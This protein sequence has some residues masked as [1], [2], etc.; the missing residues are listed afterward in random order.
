MFIAGDDDRAKQMVTALLEDFGWPVIDMGGIE[1][2]LAR[3][4]EPRMGRVL[5]PHREDTPC[6]QARGQ[7]TI[8][9]GSAL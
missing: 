2:A 6:V 7:V 5:A 1:C 9:E 3:S 8:V 4:V